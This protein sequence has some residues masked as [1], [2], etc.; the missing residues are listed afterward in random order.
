MS[1]GVDDPI[2]RQA[3]PGDATER[4]THQSAPM[5]HEMQIETTS[6]VP[7][8]VNDGVC[9][10]HLPF[11]FFKTNNLILQ[12]QMGHD[13]LNNPQL[14]TDD[15]VFIYSSHS[16]PFYINDDFVG[17]RCNQI[18]MRPAYINLLSMLSKCS[19]QLS[20]L[21]KQPPTESEVGEWVI[22]EDLNQLTMVDMTAILKADR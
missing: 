7:G 1:T 14:T 10:L 17:R 6:S 2:T 15:E 8:H 16:M 18:Q 12:T 5:E 9:S 19:E 20:P 4:N 21:W 3:A 22:I 11:L 13:T